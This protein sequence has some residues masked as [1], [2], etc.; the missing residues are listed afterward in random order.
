LNVFSKDRGGREGGET[1]PN[2]P[3]TEL[4]IAREE[5]NARLTK[6]AKKRKWNF[7]EERIE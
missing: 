5:G 3:G 1:R 7:V 4:G 6:Q 2:S